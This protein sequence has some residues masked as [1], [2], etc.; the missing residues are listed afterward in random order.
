MNKCLVKKNVKTWRTMLRTSLQ[1]LPSYAVCLLQ[2]TLGS[3]PRYQILS[4]VFARCA[5]QKTHGHARIAR[6]VEKWR[7]ARLFRLQVVPI[8]NCLC[9]IH[10]ATNY[11]ATNY[12]MGFLLLSCNSIHT[13]AMCCGVPSDAVPSLCATQ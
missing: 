5:S 9:C 1:D 2:H 3:G 8:R 10:A 6:W 13:V 7:G 12:V 11:M 4:H